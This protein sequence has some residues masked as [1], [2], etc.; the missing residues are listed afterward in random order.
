M[1]LHVGRSLLNRRL[2]EARKTQVELA[3]YLGVGQPFIS[4]V[5]NNKKK[6]SYDQAAHTA[7][8]LGCSM[9]DLHFMTKT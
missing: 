7:Y 5:A 3:E 6:F 2:K 9:E 4:M 1:A 8:F